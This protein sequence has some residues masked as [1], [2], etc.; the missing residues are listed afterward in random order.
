MNK[1]ILIL[2]TSD[3]QGA[4]EATYKI[5]KF[6]YEKKYEVA[7]V[8][9][10]QTKYEPFI[11]QVSNII[12]RIVRIKEQAIR[13][14][15]KLKSILDRNSYKTKFD[16]SYLTLD[17]NL[18]LIHEERILEKISFTPDIIIS[19]MTNGFCTSNTLLALYKKT[20]ARVYYWLLDME[21]LTGGC[22]YAWDCNGYEN[23]CKNCPAIIDVEKKDRAH[24]NFLIKRK[25][26]TEAGI[27]VIAGSGWV[28][29]QAAKSTFFKHQN[30][31]LNTNSCIDIRL[32]NNKNR[33]IAK[34][35]F[36]VDKDTKTIL[37]GS[38]HINDPRKGL[39]YFLESLDILWKNL[40]DEIREKVIIFVVGE[41]YHQTE[42]VSKIPFK[43]Q[44]IDYV[45]D[46][47]LLSLLYQATDIFVCA[48]IEDSGPMMVS[49]ALACGTP[50]VGFEMGIVGTLVKEGY[51]GYVAPVKN[52]LE[53][54]KG[55]ETIVRLE[56][57]EFEEYSNNAVKT[58]ELFS[59][60]D[61]AIK[62]LEQ[63]FE[64]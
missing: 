12:P 33:N 21:H 55:L 30:N 57:E 10:Y 28:R 45:K 62:I 25:N 48:S 36:Q 38:L 4:Y 7:L 59:S 23:E 18:N 32:M 15:P 51:N 49:E 44:I 24:Q 64:N 42:F 16:Y 46:Y 60:H 3:N 50:V 2:S 35:L 43:K 63:L 5:A 47:R 52:S 8:V 9:K 11:F 22:H 34:S 40:E 26:I 17:E 41:H 13:R 1:R 14:Y 53:L 31:I 58:V 20:N 29:N 39:K 19:G 6:L 61:Y 27:G 56:K 37:V 54:A